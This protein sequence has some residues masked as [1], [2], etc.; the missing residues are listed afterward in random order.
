VVSN[1][2]GI[3]MA[4]FYDAG[5]A[6]LTLGPEA[7]A[8]KTDAGI[9]IRFHGPSTAFGWIRP[10]P[11]RV[12]RRLRVDGGVLDRMRRNQLMCCA[13]A[14]RDRRSRRAVR[15]AD[16]RQTGGRKFFDDPIAREPRRKTRRRCDG[17]RT[18]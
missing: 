18:C 12:A 11:V 17:A 1:R 4:V 6:A 3:D 8:M 16:G 5:T 15:R 13:R 9:G 2:P 14:F 10:G 7:N